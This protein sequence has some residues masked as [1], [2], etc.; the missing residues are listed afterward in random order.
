MLYL[1]SYRELSSFFQF[2]MPF[3]YK[4]PYLF[5]RIMKHANN[6]DTFSLTIFSFRIITEFSKSLFFHTIG[7]TMSLFHSFIR[8]LCYHSLRRNFNGLFFYKTF[9]QFPQKNIFC[10]SPR[11]HDVVVIWPDACSSRRIAVFKYNA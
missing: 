10:F 5:H 2:T 11:R 6:C 9:T 8:C 7:P 3:L 4:S 1:K